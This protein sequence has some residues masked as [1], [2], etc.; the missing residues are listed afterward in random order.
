M[1]V[2]IESTTDSQEAVIAASGG[3]AEEKKD[4]VEEKSETKPK[5]ESEE[6][7]DE[8]KD[9]ASEPQDQGDDEDDEESE[10][11]EKEDKPKKKSRG[12]KKRIDKLNARLAQFE[13]EV[14]HWKSQ[15]LQQQE[16]K[17]KTGEVNNLQKD[18][19]PVPEDFDSVSEYTEALYD[20]KA[21]QAEKK[22]REMKFKEDQEKRVLDH[23]KRA[24]AFIEKHEDFDDVLDAV[25]HYQ[26]SPDFQDIIMG[27]EN[28]TEIVYELAKHDPKELERIAMAPYREAAFRLGRFDHQLSLQKEQSKE[29][30]KTTKAPAPIKPVG[31]SSTGQSSKSP[32]EMDFQ[33][34]KKWRQANA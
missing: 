34:Y 6:I 17:A 28:G 22:A 25:S 24:E 12:F 29:T 19:R 21:S 30:K 15:A 23:R 10:S 11:G 2:K 26:Y 5:P 8:T 9:E 31:K 13:Q 27:L 4:A 20:W 32:E 1:S 33:E 14:A 16:P 7:S 18:D 3:L